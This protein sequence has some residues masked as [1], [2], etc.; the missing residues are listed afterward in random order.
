MN[1]LVK[2]TQGFY[3]GFVGRI[4][5]FKTQ[6]DNRIIYTVEY[7]DSNIGKKDIE[8]QFLKKTSKGLFNRL[9]N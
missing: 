8:E 1:D 5:E 6:K 4:I 9:F 7:E 3:K 2:T